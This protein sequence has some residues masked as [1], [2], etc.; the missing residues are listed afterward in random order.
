MGST[1]CMIPSLLSIS[2]IWGLHAFDGLHFS[3]NFDKGLSIIESLEDSGSEGLLDI[4]DG[5]GLGNGGIR[6]SSSLGLGS[7]Y[8]VGRQVDEEIILGHLAVGL[9]GHNVFVF[10]RSGSSDEG[11][12]E[13]F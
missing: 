11:E 10:E 13:S 6:V 3:S 2:L 4:L 1:D 9:G 12:S 8:E 7:R 5:S